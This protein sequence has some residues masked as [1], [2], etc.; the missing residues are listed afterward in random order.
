MKGAEKEGFLPSRTS[1]VAVALAGSASV[2]GS[3]GKKFI[4]PTFKILAFLHF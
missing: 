4:I 3:N 2:S 1:L